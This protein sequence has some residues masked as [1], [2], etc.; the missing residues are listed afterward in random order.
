MRSISSHLPA[1]KHISGKTHCEQFL[2]L[3]SFY[4]S[5]NTNLL[6]T[7][8]EGRTWEYWPEVVAYGPLGPYKNDQ[9]PLF[10][11]TARKVSKA[12]LVS[13][14]LHGIRAMLLFE[15]NS[16]RKQKIHSL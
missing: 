7:E 14:L 4:Q 1:V 15:F 13:S 8:K 11:C 5:I 9:G 3:P 6:L 2:S 10:P 16:F 12:R